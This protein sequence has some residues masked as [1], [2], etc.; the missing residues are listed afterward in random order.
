[1]VDKAAL[2]EMDLRILNLLSVRGAQLT[3]A[4]I[5]KELRLNPATVNYKLRKLEEN[6]VILEYRY[7]INPFKLGFGVMVWLCI[8]IRSHG[9]MGNIFRELEASPYVQ[10]VLTTGGDYDIVAKAFFKDGHEL[11][12][13]LNNLE[14]KMRGDADRMHVIMV[15]HVHK[16]HQ[17]PLG[18]MDLQ[19]AKLDDKDKSILKYV[20][21]NPSTDIKQ[22][23]KNLGLHRNT[24]SLRWKRLF[25]ERV[26][27]KK[28]AIVNPLYYSELGTGFSTT[29]LIDTD[30]GYAEKVAEQIMQCKEIHELTCINYPH[31]L[32]AI[33]RTADVPSCQAFLNRLYKIPMLKKTKT[34]IIFESSEE[35][36][37]T[38][39]LGQNGKI[40]GKMGK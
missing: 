25:D 40:V 28:T 10:S 12:E 17:T 33:V 32:V 37:L 18:K 21:Q 11:N 3:E 1:M 24:V 36:F 22:M 8:T 29:V 9:S 4:Q 15:R 30:I 23:A 34:S 13:F 19:K 7:R 35:G 39:F 16:L 14:E 27:I 38:Q 5:A 31:D 26:I 2:S 20:L 6:R